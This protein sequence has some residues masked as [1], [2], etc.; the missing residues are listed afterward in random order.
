MLDDIGT[1]EA[2]MAEMNNTNDSPYE[3]Y[4]IKTVFDLLIDNVVPE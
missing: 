3:A 2:N 1:T 4:Y